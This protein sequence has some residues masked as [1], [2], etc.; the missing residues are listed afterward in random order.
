MLAQNPLWK[1][2]FF[3][4][5]VSLTVACSSDSTIDGDGGTGGNSPGDGD[6]DSGDGD[7]VPPIVGQCVLDT[8][9]L[10]V[11]LTSDSCYSP[12]C[13][14]PVAAS[15]ADVLAND[16]LVEWDG[17]VAPPVPDACKSQSDEQVAC[18]LGCAQPPSCV[19]PSCN[20][21]KCELAVSQGTTGCDSSSNGSG[22]GGAQS[23]C[24]KLNEERVTALEGARACIANGIVAECTQ[25]NVILDDCGCSVAVNDA[26]K[27]SVQTAQAAYDAWNK[28]CEPPAKCQLVDCAAAS[29]KKTCDDSS[30]SD[31]SGVCHFE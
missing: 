27:S 20:A 25:D 24:T 1:S 16:C 28:S 26:E 10:A 11:S 22:G 3:F 12:G 15:E 8:D 9:C 21:G 17:L 29:G 31:G 2:W 14:I 19:T 4:A 18:T 13:E 5:A 23:D 30:S 7:S 6:G